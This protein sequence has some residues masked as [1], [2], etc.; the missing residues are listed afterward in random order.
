MALP[1]AER[2]AA[3]KARREDVPLLFLQLV[4]EAAGRY[5]RDEVDVPARVIADIARRAATTT[6]HGGITWPTS[7]H[8]G[9][10]SAS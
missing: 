1:N 5:R 9:R 10:S 3:L 6:T 2:Q 7:K 8:V 4:R